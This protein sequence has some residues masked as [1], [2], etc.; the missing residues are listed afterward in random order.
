MTSPAIEERIR[1]GSSRVELLT[2]ASVEIT[3]ADRARLPEAARLLPAGTRVHL[4]FLGGEAATEREATAGAVADLGLTPVPHLAARRIRSRPE[5]VGHLDRLA[6]CGA[7]ERAFLVAGDP[8]HPLGPYDDAL[9]LLDSPLLTGHRELGVAGYPDGHPA[10]A[11]ETLWRALATKA[12][13]L[14]ARGQAGSVVTQFG[15]DAD[16]VLGWI[17]EARQRG[18]ELPV[19]VG[20]AGPASARKLLR[21]A[22][23]FGVASSAGIVRKY[24]LSLTNLLQPAGP[25]RF[26][27]ALV[28]GYD[29][30]RHGEVTLHLYTFGDL[31]RAAEWLAVAL[32]RSRP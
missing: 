24:G 16:R 25:D 32:D 22:A 19:R 13:V 8:P 15:F 7:G 3:A 11:T 18:V 14:A 21:F 30:V 12:A 23:R 4:T 9:A 20:V 26:V 31:P 17:A 6:A 28:S 2:G 29:P 27:E 10:I 5:L 1:R